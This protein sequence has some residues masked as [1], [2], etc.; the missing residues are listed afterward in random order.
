MAL[1]TEFEEGELVLIIGGVIVIGYGIWKGFGALGDA[2]KMLWSDITGVFSSWDA[3]FAN[4]DVATNTVVTQ[5]SNP[6]NAGKT[7]EVNTCPWVFGS[8]I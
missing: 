3:T 7:P 1:E 8:S 5:S 6:Q 2:L 4:P